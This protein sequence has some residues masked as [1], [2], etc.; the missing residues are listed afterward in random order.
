MVQIS[1]LTA[2]YNSTKY[3][4]DVL[5]YCY[6]VHHEKKDKCTVLEAV[7]FI[8]CRLKASYYYIR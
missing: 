1:C 3:A 4:V 6:E 5:T 7:L 2:L 8:H